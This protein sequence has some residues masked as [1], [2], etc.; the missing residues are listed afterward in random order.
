MKFLDHYNEELRHLRDS[1]ARFAKEH[2]QVASELGLHP[3]AVTDPFVE[4][5]LEGVAYLT[6]R[7]HTRLDRE[8]AEFAQQTLA[9]VVPL[10]MSATPSMTSFAFHP[11]FSSPEAHRGTTIQRGS[12]INARIPGRTQPVQFSTARDVTLLPLKLAD[13]ECNRSL[14]DIPA[15]LSNSLAAGQ[16]VIRLRFQLEGTTTVNQLIQPKS[17]QNQ[18]LHLSLAGD[19]PRAYQLHRTFMVDTRAWFAVVRTDQGEQ[20]L[21]LPLSGLQMSGIK[22]QEALLPPDL[23][24]LPG[25]RLLREYFAQPSNCLG[26]ELDV[27]NQIAKQAPHARSFDLLFSLKRLPVELVGDID[28]QQFRLFATPVINL[29]PK[30]LD[31]VAYDHSK[32]EQWLPVDRM[33]PEN[34]HLWQLTEVS[35]VKRDGQLMNA[36]PVLE[37]GGYDG[38]QAPLRFSLQREVVSYAEGSKNN[39]SDQLASYDTVSLSSSADSALLESLNTI[40]SKGL[41]SDR[42]WRL[43]ALLDADLQ[44]AETGAVSRI[45]CLFM[46]SMARR[47]PTVEACWD[48][49]SQLGQNLLSIANQSRQDV[50][51]RLMQFVMLA[52]QA[53]NALDKQRLDS[54]RSLNLK[55]G[56]ARAGRSV[57]MAW[58]RAT[59]VQL[60]VSDSRHADN[61]GWLFARILAQALSQSVNLNEGIDVELLL[62]GQSVSGHS[63]TIDADGVLR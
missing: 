25:L 14:L 40:L 50:T 8:C 52:A 45:E 61:G 57:P 36:S 9:R 13:V 49:A 1:G 29:Y 46:P 27:L 59:Q 37:T 2:P 17:Q 12:I 28:I 20:V 23:G 55:A 31:P 11:D 48:A 41:V 24:G 38:E 6:A 54:I 34:Y 18:L 15:S 5:L 26:M 32:T 60:D 56:F 33:R 30:R 42:G 44:L 16:A 22:D 53:D 62:D 58:V 35:V 19:L 4:R 47:S 7:V 10:Y 51:A 3:D 43:Q 63:N 39:N 21:N